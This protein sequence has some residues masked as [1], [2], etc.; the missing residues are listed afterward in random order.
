MGIFDIAFGA[1]IQ[2]RSYFLGFGVDAI[3]LIASVNEDVIFRGGRRF[4]LG[5]VISLYFKGVFVL[6]L[7]RNTFLSFT[8]KVI[9]MSDTEKLDLILKEIADLRSDTKEMKQT[10]K[11]MDKRL[12][13]IENRL[14]NIEPWISVDNSHLAFKPAT[15]A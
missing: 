7:Q 11:V 6:H 12:T 9:Q 13:L 3:F 1:Y 8:V 10:L 5:T 4:F 15:A 2:F 14:S